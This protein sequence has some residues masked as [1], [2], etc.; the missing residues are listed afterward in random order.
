MINTINYKCSSYPCHDKDKLESCVL[1][2]C[3]LYPC[4]TG[5]GE[6]IENGMFGE[7]I[8]DCSKCTWPHEKER[9]EKLFDYL[10][11]NFDE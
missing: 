2:Y 4:N 7:P 8:L 1:C 9:I 11:Y 6:W 5:R 3:P 10:K